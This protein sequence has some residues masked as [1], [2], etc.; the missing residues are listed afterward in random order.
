MPSAK[1]WSL[2]SYHFI[3]K[4]DAGCRE[5]ARLG[6]TS[7][8]CKGSLMITRMLFFINAGIFA[9]I[10]LG[11][12]VAAETM[13]KNLGIGFF[14]PQGLTDVR[15]T[16]GGMCL[17]IGI[18]FAMAAAGRIDA[19][20]AL[21]ASLCLYLGLGLARL[22]GLIFDHS[23]TTLLWGFFAIEAFLAGWSAFLLGKG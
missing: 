2:P 1:E 19:S 10:G 14:S 8:F 5:N 15:A 3:S 4:I 22:G 13:S 23:S 7:Y 20:A 21:W 18:F 16:Y 11:F 9:A 17:G 6:D 12:L